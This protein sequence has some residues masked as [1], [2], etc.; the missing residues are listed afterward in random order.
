MRHLLSYERFE[1]RELLAVGTLDDEV[2]R[3]LKRIVE[4]AW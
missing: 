4:C 1:A 3:H 2:R